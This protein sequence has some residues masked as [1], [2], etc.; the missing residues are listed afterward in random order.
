[1]QTTGMP[2]GVPSRTEFERMAA[3]GR[4]HS[5]ERG[6][7]IPSDSDLDKAQSPLDLGRLYGFTE[8]DIAHYYHVRRHG[9]QVAYTEYLRDLEHAKVPPAK[10]ESN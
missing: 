3:R 5:V 8:D 10:V 6:A 2:K 4:L 1:M 9:H 7:L